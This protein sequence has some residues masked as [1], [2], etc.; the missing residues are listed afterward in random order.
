MTMYRNLVG[1]L[2]MSTVL[3]ATAFGTLAAHADTLEKARA[4]GTIRVGVGLMGTKPFVWEENGEYKGIEADL[5]AELVK[6]LGIA[7]F[8]YVVTEWST[9]IPGLKADRWDMLVTG[10]VKTEERIQGGGIAMSDPYVM[11][12]DVIIVSEDSPIQS[13]ADLEGKILAS[14]LGS[15]DSLVAHSMVERGLAAEV[16]DFNTYAEPFLALANKQV[17]AVIFDQMTYMGFAET[18]SDIRTVGEPILYIP[19]ADWA[20]AHEAANYNL[21]GVSVGVRA[22]DAALLAA[23]NEALSEMDADG[24]R[25]KILEAYG[26][27]DEQQTREAMMK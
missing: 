7:D 26:V 22:E 8:E 2:G 3:L 20:E 15:T 14:L 27:W 18:M 17:D 9:L 6:R 25:Q 12:Y 13:E 21:G 24:T 16:K 1:A 23:I 4:E 19:A 5:T 10:M 11:A